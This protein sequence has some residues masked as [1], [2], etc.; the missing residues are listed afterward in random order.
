MPTPVLHLI[1]YA[2]FCIY[3]ILIDILYTGY[4]VELMAMIF[5]MNWNVVNGFS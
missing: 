1:F 5:K 2:G 3:D 4:F